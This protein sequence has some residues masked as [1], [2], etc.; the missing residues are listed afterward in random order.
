MNCR[1]YDGVKT[2]Q[3]RV[4]KAVEES[5]ERENVMTYFRQLFDG[6]WTIKMH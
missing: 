1:S 5:K 4:N 2:K 6:F 3:I